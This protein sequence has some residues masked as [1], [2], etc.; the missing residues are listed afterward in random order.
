MVPDI[1]PKGH[2]FTGALAY[3][4]H[5][6]R[7]GDEPQ[8]QTSERVAWTQTRNLMT[9]DPNLARR[10]MVA[11]AL[12][13]A[14][15][16]KAAGV[17]NSGRKSNL[18]VY[19]Y[20]LAWH[21]DEA[22]EINKAE[23]IAA[24]DASLKE[25]K[26]DH[27]QSIIVCHTDQNHPH[28]HVIIN[29][30]DP[31]DGR[32]HPF[33]NDRLQLSDWANKYERER[34]HIVTPAREEKRKQRELH[35]DKKARQDFALAKRKEAS[36]RAKSDM[37]PASMLKDLGDAQKVRHR[38][39]WRELSATNKKRRNAIYDDFRNR[40]V[41]ASALHKK[42]VKPFWAQ[43][44][45]KERDRKKE[46]NERE[47]GIIGVVQNAMAATAYQHMTG[48][49]D[50]RGKLS[51]TFSNVLSSQK[52]RAAFDDRLNMDK[53]E[54]RTRLK[55]ILDSEIGN[56]KSN[57]KSTLADQRDTFDQ[58]RGELI[59][60][61]DGEW[62]KV[63]EA[64]KQLRARPHR[65]GGSGGKTAEDPHARKMGN[66]LKILSPK[67]EARE[68]YQD[69][70]AG[71]SQMKA[72]PQQGTEPVKRDFDNSKKAQPATKQ[73]ATKR[74]TVSTPAPAPAPRGETPRATAKSQVVPKGK[75]WSQKPA[76]AEKRGLSGTAPAKKDWNKTGASMTKAKV[77]KPKDWS[78]K[79]DR[80]G[81]IKKA[82]TPRRDLD[83]SR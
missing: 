23:M 12:Q 14:E 43:H 83:R 21:P 63:R 56:I 71:Q 58:N 1:A 10:I 52:R 42:E 3:Y 50:G 32:M 73:S 81:A 55:S 20:S 40:I 22:G 60:R 33:K 59:K 75:D 82:P 78:K 51:A 41:G 70:R 7:Q 15:L 65:G 11:T 28:V 16:K 74:T 62:N 77:E 49:M 25:L 45:R 64:W 19:A 67:N 39:E 18:H 61:Q 27:L 37:S 68:K 38:Q 44:F 26:A 57:R 17:K 66:R 48:E 53:G 5:D 30:V 24:V 2:S 54:L 9:D 35:A 47:T 8:P 31:A 76:K 69:R 29:R 36:A 6:K 4:L 13:S 34:G 72:R 80:A 46:F 79:A